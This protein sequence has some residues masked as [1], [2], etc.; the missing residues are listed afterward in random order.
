MLYS[1]VALFSNIPLIV[2]SSLSI[3]TER[4]LEKTIHDASI[5]CF[6][7]QD[8][9]EYWTKLILKGTLSPLPAL[10]PFYLIFQP[11][12]NDMSIT[13]QSHIIHGG[14]YSIV[15]FPLTLRVIKRLHLYSQQFVG[16]RASIEL[17]TGANLQ[18]MPEI[19]G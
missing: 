10:L 8:L 9:G 13:M 2:V 17:S 16:S 7:H 15:V 3:D 14:L 5:A 1:K 12:M 11:K 18:P 4:F 19:Q 6:S